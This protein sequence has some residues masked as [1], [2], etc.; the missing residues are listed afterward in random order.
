MDSKWDWDVKCIF[1]SEFLVNLPSKVALN[2]LG[3][4]KKIKFITSDIVAVVDES[5]MDPDVFQVLQTVWVKAIGIPKLPELSLLL[6]SLLDW[7]EI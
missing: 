1:G 6:W 3:K 4:M 2:L 5:D 7:L